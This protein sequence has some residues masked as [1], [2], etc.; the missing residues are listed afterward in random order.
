MNINIK[1]NTDEIIKGL[2]K[3]EQQFVP[4][5]LNTAVNKTGTKVTSVVRRH[6]ANEAG[7]TQAKLKQRGFFANFR[8]SLRTMTF[9]MVVRWGAIP[10]KDFNPRQTKEGVSHKAWGKT[11]IN[12]GDE[13][14]YGS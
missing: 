6:V 1:S 5:A 9:T 2:N 11:Q 14:C 8:S 7:M 10:L 3:F 12:K 4:R 13:C